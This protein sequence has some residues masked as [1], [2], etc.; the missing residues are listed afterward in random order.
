MFG[1]GT[2]PSFNA[3][4]TGAFVGQP[5]AITAAGATT[6]NSGITCAGYTTGLTA[7]TTYWFDL[8]VKAVGGSVTLVNIQFTFIE[9]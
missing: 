8:G 9:L 7:G 4:Q 3:P 6:G 1:T 2:A 5:Q